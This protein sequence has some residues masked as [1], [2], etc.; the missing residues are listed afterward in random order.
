MS[1]VFAWGCL[2]WSEEVEV[3]RCKGST[4]LWLWASSH[5]KITIS[6][7]SSD[8]IVLYSSSLHSL[9]PCAPGTQREWRHCESQIPLTTLP[10]SLCIEYIASMWDGLQFRDVSPH[11]HEQHH[12]S[13]IQKKCCDLLGKNLSLIYGSAGPHKPMWWNNWSRL[14]GNLLPIHHI[15]WTLHIVTS[16]LLDRWRSTLSEKFFLTREISDCHGSEYEDNSL[17]AC[18]TM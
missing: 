17:L 15:S 11:R 12:H 13:V 1:E 10:S 16:T 4:F 6:V 5:S 14:A 18:C 2:L 3:T 7:S 8:A 9:S